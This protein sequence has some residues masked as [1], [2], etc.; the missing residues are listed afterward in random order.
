MNQRE[1]VTRRDFLEE[2]S[3]LGAAAVAGPTVW[4]PRGGRPDAD[5]LAQQQAAWVGRPVD[6]LPTPVLLIELDAFERN[7]A[8]MQ[9][10]FAAH[11][12]GYRPHGKAH[13]SPVIGAK[14]I[15]HGALGQCAGKI[16]EAEVLAA[17]GLD[18]ILITSEVVGVGKIERL[19]KL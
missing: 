3:T 17:G 12:H 8:R 13:K 5:E 18:D 2:G 10:H 19:M 15:A 16:G 7:L 1:K 6:E 11:P 9:Q 14:Q 4:L